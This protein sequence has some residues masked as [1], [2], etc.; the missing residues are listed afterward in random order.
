MLSERTRKSRRAPARPAEEPENLVIVPEAEGQLREPAS[1]RALDS[2]FARCARRHRARLARCGL[3]LAV[4]AA[5]AGG[6]TSTGRRADPSQ[7]S[8]TASDSSPADARRVR[9]A[10]RG[11]S[12]ESCERTIT[13]MLRRTPGVLR[14]DVSVERS[15]AVVFYDPARTTPAA[16]ATVVSALGYDTSVR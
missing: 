12:C 7:P 10:V 4:A 14:T 15:E 8:A 16:L 9:L 3:L 2:P 1:R 13:A 6:E 11:M 5:C